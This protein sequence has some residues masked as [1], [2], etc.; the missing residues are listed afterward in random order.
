MLTLPNLANQLVLHVNRSEFHQESNGHGPRHVSFTCRHVIYMW[1]CNFWTL[2][3]TH[4][5]E[6]SKGVRNSP[7]IQWACS[8]P[9]KMCPSCCVGR[10]PFNANFIKTS[11]VTVL[12]CRTL[13]LSPRWPLAS[14]QCLEHSLYLCTLMCDVWAAGD[15]ISKRCSMFYLWMSFVNTHLGGDH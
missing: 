2:C 7:E 15:G 5:C 11:D 8:Q 1:F 3:A 12:Q 4:K 10:F 13:H 14:H 6:G 9:C